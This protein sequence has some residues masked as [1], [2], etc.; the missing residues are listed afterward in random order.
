MFIQAISLLEKLKMSQPEID[1]LEWERRNKIIQTLGMIQENLHTEAKVD[2]EAYMGHL[3][4]LFRFLMVH[5]SRSEP[6]DRGAVEAAVLD[7]LSRTRMKTPDLEQSDWEPEPDLFEEEEGDENPQ[8]LA[9]MPP[10]SFKDVR[11]PEPGYFKGILE[12]AGSKGNETDG[13][14]PSFAAAAAAPPKPVPEPAVGP[15]K[16]KIKGVFAADSDRYFYIV[17]GDGKKIYLPRDFE[18]G[19]KVQSI[20]TFIGVLDDKGH[21]SEGEILRT[22]LS[23]VVSKFTSQDKDHYKITT[24][25]GQDYRVNTSHEGLHLKE[26]FGQRIKEKYGKGDKALIVRFHAHR[27]LNKEG[28]VNTEH[29]GRK[30]LP[31]VSEI[32]MD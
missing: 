7:F 10:M 14:P 9:I 8:M 22:V 16:Q 5:L 28:L 26:S 25:D 4:L 19:I 23:G 1:F 18:T 15:V 17:T 24:A 2:D 29:N 11:K 6:G 32:L 12:E 31:N 3:I 27:F 20:V 30:L 21:F 13:P